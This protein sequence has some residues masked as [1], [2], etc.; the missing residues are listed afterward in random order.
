MSLAINI[1]VYNYYRIFFYRYHFWNK[2]VYTTIGGFTILITF[3]N[4]KRMFR[5]V[6]RLLKNTKA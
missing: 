6:V 3:N 5:V 4:I 2:E 1:Q